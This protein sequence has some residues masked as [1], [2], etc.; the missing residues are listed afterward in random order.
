MPIIPTSDLKDTHYEFLFFFSLVFPSFDLDFGALV[1]T[2]IQINMEMMHFQINI[3]GSPMRW[4]TDI[5]YSTKNSD[6][7]AIFFA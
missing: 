1:S 5:L 7:L 3:I 4:Q 2:S 6:L